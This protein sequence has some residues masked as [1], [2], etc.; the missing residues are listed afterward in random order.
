[1]IDTVVRMPGTY[2]CVLLIK[3][4]CWDRDTA[5]VTETLVT[6]TVL[7]APHGMN[8]PSGGRENDCT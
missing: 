3:L 1:M 6:G 5:V 4:L 2:S 7:L 8:A